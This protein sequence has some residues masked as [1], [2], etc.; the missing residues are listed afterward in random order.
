MN[1]LSRLFLLGTLLILITDSAS[2]HHS[3]AAYNSEEIAAIE[4]RIVRYEWASPHVYVYVEVESD[5]GQPEI[6]EVETGPPA[7]MTRLGWS[8][9]TLTEGESVVVNGNPSVDS[10]RKIMYLDW[11]ERPD[12]SIVSVDGDR[13]RATINDTNATGQADS[14]EGIWTTVPGSSTGADRE[15]TAKGAEA[16][17]SFREESMHPGAGCIP[18]ASP[19]LMTTPVT[20]LIEVKE[21]SIMIREEFWAAER[22]IHLDIGSHDGAERTIQGHSIGRWED[23]VLVVDTTHFAEHRIGNGWGLPS[24]SEKKLTEWFELSP[25]GASLT[26]RYEVTDPEYLITPISGENLWVYRPDLEF[27]PEECNPD[28]ASRFLQR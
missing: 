21:D 16:M 12:G 8:S 3:R 11:I 4:G 15:V 24:G 6:W 25:D 17:E 1:T 7:F 20:K 19:S 9:Q 14:L 18:D 5:S 2:G 13:F 22:T 28:N 27:A 23:N 10:D 26:Y